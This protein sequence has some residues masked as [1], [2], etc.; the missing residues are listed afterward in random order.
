[1]EHPPSDADASW[2]KYTSEGRP[3]MGIIDDAK[4][5]AIEDVTNKIRRGVYS[6]WLGLLRFT[7]FCATIIVVVWLLT[8]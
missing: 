7:L 8:K 3:I 4:E 6:P 2:I 1:M 5:R